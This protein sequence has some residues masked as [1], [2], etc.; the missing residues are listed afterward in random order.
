LSR[1]AS[2]LLLDFSKAVFGALR[3][4]FLRKQENPTS[5]SFGFRTVLAKTS[6][7]VPLLMPLVS[8]GH[9]TWPNLPAFRIHAVVILN[10]QTGRD[11]F[12]HAAL[13]EQILDV[14]GS[15]SQ[16]FQGWTCDRFL[17]NGLLRFGN[18]LEGLL[19]ERRGCR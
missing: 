16:C 18:F 10:V 4:I 12:T 1:A 2:L 15:P 6:T 14:D 8:T 17:G 5:M 19:F 7:L 3:P 13:V 9:T 11:S